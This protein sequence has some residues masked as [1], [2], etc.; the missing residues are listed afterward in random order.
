MPLLPMLM[1]L[2]LVVTV[3]RS[4]RGLRVQRR[5]GGGGEFGT[6]GA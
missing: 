2:K 6:F 1:Q 3:A 5:R 4:S